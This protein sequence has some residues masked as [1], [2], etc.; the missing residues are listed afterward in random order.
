M[1]EVL[2]IKTPAGAFVPMDDTEAAKVKRIKSGDVSRIDIV[3]MRNGRFFRKWWVLA[4]YAFDIWADTMPEQEYKGQRVQPEFD[5]FRRDLTI[6][7]GYFRPV[8]A[9]NGEMRVEAE[10]LKWS[11]MDEDRFEKLYSATINAVL[12]KVLDSTR[13][14]EADIRAHVDRVMEFDS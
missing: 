7:A 6:L 13:L 5:R 12:T 4:K 3:Q 14:T 1:S 8:F 10:S 9:A 11:E 2:C